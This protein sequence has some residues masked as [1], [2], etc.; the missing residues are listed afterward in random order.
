MADEG[1]SST[2]VLIAAVLQLIFFFVGAAFTALFAFVLA[3]LP[4][5]PPSYLPP[6]SPP[7]AELM[8][9]ML[10]LTIAF[11][12]VTV[13]A[14][15]FSIVWFMWRSVPSQ[16]KVGLI[17]TGILALIFSGVIPGILALVGGVIGPKESAPIPTSTPTLTSKPAQSRH[18]EG[19][20]YCSTCGNPVANPNAQY[21]GV[22]GA[23]LV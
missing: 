18:E 20:K 1:T 11:G 2:L 14:L 5:I 4:T 16:H 3:V 10:S 23:S 6:G 8:N 7:L 19:V 15:I 22:C 12:V 21:C 13:I 9:G 17:I